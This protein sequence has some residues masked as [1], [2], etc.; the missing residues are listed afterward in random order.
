MY[1]NLELVDISHWDFSPVINMKT[2]HVDYD[3]GHKIYCEYVNSKHKFEVTRPTQKP[4]ID[5]TTE[6]Y[7]WKKQLFAIHT[8]THVHETPQNYRQRIKQH[9]KKIKKIYL[10]QKY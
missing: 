6:P 10:S 8:K 1:V 2:R 7:M 5:K 9:L 4:K 3:T